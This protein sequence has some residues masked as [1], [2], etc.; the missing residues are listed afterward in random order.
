MA[1]YK[2]GKVQK[3]QSIKMAK[4]KNDQVQKWQQRTTMAKFYFWQSQNKIVKTIYIYMCVYISGADCS[5]DMFTMFLNSHGF[6]FHC[7]FFTQL[8]TLRC[9]KQQK[10]DCALRTCDS[11]EYANPVPRRILSGDLPR[12]ARARPPNART[13][14][15]RSRF[16]LLSPFTSLK[17]DSAG[18]AS[19][20]NRFREIDSATE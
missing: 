2:N 3:W 9:R 17:I 19:N 1:K 13:R 8:A 12:M 11:T 6:K 15:T 18:L 4:Y 7:T 5:Y 14:H 16:G 10:H 20:K